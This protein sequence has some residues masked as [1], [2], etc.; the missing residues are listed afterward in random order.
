MIPQNNGLWSN[1]SQLNWISDV[2][3]KMMMLAKNRL[4]MLTTTLKTTVIIFAGL[5]NMIVHL[6]LFDSYVYPLND[7]K[8]RLARIFLPP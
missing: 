6:P 7:T 5:L 4:A 2:A 1:R 3:S 8:Q